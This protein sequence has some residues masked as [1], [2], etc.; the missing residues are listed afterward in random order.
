MVLA[1]CYGGG[2]PVS[3]DAA[4]AD[5]AADAAGDAAVVPDAAAADAPADA[6][7]GAAFEL[8]KDT[9]DFGPVPLGV[10]HAYIGAYV[11][12]TGSVP[13]TYTVSATGAFAIVG[14]DCTERAQQPGWSCG[15][16]IDTTATTFGLTS[17]TL[18]VSAGGVAK[19]APVTAT[20]EGYVSA[21]AAGPGSVVMTP[22]VPDCGG[23]CFPEGTVVTITEFP[24]AMEHFTGWSDPACGAG[25]QCKHTVDATP[26]DVTASFA[27]DEATFALTITGDGLGEVQISQPMHGVVAI[28][29]A[30]CTVPVALD[31]GL[32]LIAATPD[33]FGTFSAPCTAG[34]F[35]CE[36]PAGSASATADFHAASNERDVFPLATAG[37]VYSVDFT[38]AGELVLGTSQGVLALDASFV[39]RWTS[40]LVGVARVASDGGVFVIT[41][42]DID[43]LDAGGALL[44]TRLGGFPLPD[45]TLKT[46]SGHPFAATPS[47]GIAVA[48]GTSG[49]DIVD[50]AGATI[51]S[52]ALD[53]RAG[54]LATG[55]DG[56]IYVGTIF[57]D[58]AY[59]HAFAADGTPQP[60][61]QYF[62]NANDC[63]LAVGT[64]QLA[65]TQAS[66]LA[67]YMFVARYGLDRSFENGLSTRDVFHLDHAN[68]GVALDAADDT[69]WFHAVT[70]EF[71]VPFTG[72]DLVKLTSAGTIEWSI[73]RP[74]FTSYFNDSSA[75]G[76]DVYDVAASRDG[77]AAIAGVF[78]DLTGDRA[79]VEVFP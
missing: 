34:F 70:P 6:V 26:F 64:N 24:Q 48:R 4:A 71:T 23:H 69:F 39:I 62:G 5:A 7:V 75:T 27:P 12:N 65:I 79:I 28:C 59:L 14:G 73:D 32:T 44:W 77:H 58:I 17:G 50:A 52:P 56:S 15:I 25:T 53:G 67:A 54:C 51:A 22:V 31:D 30:S 43:K 76:L 72:L 8:S 13:L 36:L 33:N 49:F 66:Q 21:E 63:A 47:G 3:V 2:S 10:T 16:A 46:A 68:T 19:S 18:E 29:N 61:F 78:H 45:A 57:G 40:P 38:A 55:T 20:L 35:A 41:P 60:D 74:A 37:I 11:L 1:G 42:T 9:Y